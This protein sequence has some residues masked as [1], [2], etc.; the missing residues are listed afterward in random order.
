MS[1]RLVVLLHFQVR[2]CTIFPWCK[3]QE[4]WVQAGKRHKCRR[5]A[6]Q[7]ERTQLDR[8]WFPGRTTSPRFS[9]SRMPGSAWQRQGSRKWEGWARAHGTGWTAAEPFA[10]SESNVRTMATQSHC[11]WCRGWGSHRESLYALNRAA[12]STP[13]Q[14]GPSGWVQ[15]SL[16]RQTAL[17]FSRAVAEL[18]CHTFCRW[19][20]L[21]FQR[22]WKI[23]QWLRWRL[24]LG[25]ILSGRD[26]PRGGS[27]WH[28]VDST[29]WWCLSCERQSKSLLL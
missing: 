11:Q 1:Y 26:S 6:P 7:T 14:A 20:S 12:Q 5:I 21:C 16:A 23:R 17:I 18:E 4:L 25:S 19:G 27:M 28:L 15:R 8:P 9:S 3:A 22:Q 2:L 24:C 10:P 13:P 29:Q